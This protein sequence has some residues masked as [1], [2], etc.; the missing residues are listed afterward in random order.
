M[1]RIIKIYCIR[2]CHGPAVSLSTEPNDHQP[3]PSVSS[4]NTVTPHTSDHPVEAAILTSSNIFP[5]GKSVCGG[6]MRFDL[7]GSLN[8]AYSRTVSQLY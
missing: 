8:I 1:G 6:A 5:L 4:V 2:P 7:R 3:P